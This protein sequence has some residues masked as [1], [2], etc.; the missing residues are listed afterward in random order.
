MAL[1]TR[2]FVL[3]S[4][5]CDAYL[6]PSASPSAPCAETYI[7]ETAPGTRPSPARDHAPLMV[8][9]NSLLLCGGKDSAVAAIYDGNRYSDCWRA[10]ISSAGDIT[11]TKV[12]TTA[13]VGR[14]SYAW[15]FRPSTGALY[16]FGGEQKW[17]SP[18][19]AI[20][21]EVYSTTSASAGAVWTLEATMQLPARRSLHAAVVDV[22]G[23]EDIY[24]FAG[25]TNAGTGGGT[26]A[27][28]VI[29]WRWSGSVWTVLSTFT[30]S[31]GDLLASTRS[32]PFM[33]PF[34]STTGASFRFGVYGGEACC[35]PLDSNLWVSAAGGVPTFTSR[36]LGWPLGTSIAALPAFYAPSTTNI[37]AFGQLGTSVL[38]CTAD[39]GATWL[40]GL[41]RS[42]D[43]GL[44][45][46]ASIDAGSA[47]VWNASGNFVMFVG[48]TGGRAGN[49]Y[50]ALPA[51]FRSEPSASRSATSSVSPSPSISPTQT[52][53]TVCAAGTFST[54]TGC[55]VCPGGHYCPAGTSSWALLNCG[56]GWYCPLGSDA[57]T[58]C[59]IQVP[60]TGGWG[61]LQVQGPAFLVETARC[62]NHCFWNFT[63]GNGA[64]STC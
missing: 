23:A 43:Y 11:W 14:S 55:T 16:V 56:K 25:M 50:R 61:A 6:P 42:A 57:P 51:R 7:V 37:L 22:A 29:R 12:A 53:S 5:L 64:L 8:Q 44:A 9:G 34:Q 63:T 20:L 39:G 41:D 27:N 21:R 26:Y 18:N 49:Y 60:P 40:D 48:S 10:P 59:P 2:F 58:P 33:F 17:T 32:A 52:A 15:A 35:W 19:R 38:K 24:I 46:T 3:F 4:A 47:V 1:F 45:P 31:E 54:A 28:T 36:S 30:G 62:V 13:W